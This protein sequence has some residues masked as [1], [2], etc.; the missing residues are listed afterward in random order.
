MPVAEAHLE[1]SQTYTMQPFA[2]M[3]NY[4][5]KK[6]SI[7]DDWLG[8]R[9]TT[10]LGVFKIS[11]VFNSQNPVF[12]FRLLDDFLQVIKRANQTPVEKFDFPQTEA[13]EIGWSTKPLVSKKMFL[14]LYSSLCF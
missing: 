7:V 6:S 11:K 5:R 14:W 4:F 2:K 9:Y 1:P 13:Q 10:E 3:M 12:T 8:S